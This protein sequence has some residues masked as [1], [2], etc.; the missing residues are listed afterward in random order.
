MKRTTP[1]LL[2]VVLGGFLCWGS[3]GCSLDSN[4]QKS[5]DQSLQPEPAAIRVVPGDA[6][7]LIL[8]EELSDPRVR[9]CIELFAAAGLDQSP[10]SSVTLKGASA[11]GTEITLTITLFAGK[12]STQEGLIAYI[13]GKG[14]TAV[15]P[16]IMRNDESTLLPEQ[17]G[18]N[19]IEYAVTKEGQVVAVGDGESCASDSTGSGWSWGTF[20]HCLRV[21]LRQRTPDLAGCVAGC[22]FAGPAYVECLAACGG[23]MGVA[24]TL[25]CAF[26]QL[27]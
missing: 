22:A 17:R 13:Q 10:T 16:C 9:K 7:R 3:L 25:E 21:E 4:D 18:H 26:Q 14:T 19:L 5:H 11:D 1:A 27:E 20:W 2:T 24:M 23:G 12:D 6:G 8:K 15:C